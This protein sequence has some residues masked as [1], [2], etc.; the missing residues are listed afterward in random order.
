[1]D[2]VAD[3]GSTTEWE[4]LKACKV[5]ADVLWLLVATKNEKILLAIPQY[6]ENTDWA[7]ARF[8]KRRIHVPAMPRRRVSRLFACVE[9]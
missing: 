2:N 4:A 1:M 9:N 5:K 6:R 8:M 7:H 3:R